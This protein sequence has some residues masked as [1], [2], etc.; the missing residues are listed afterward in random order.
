[1]RIILRDQKQR[2]GFGIN[3]QVVTDIICG[4]IL[5]FIHQFY[6]ITNLRFSRC[7]RIHISNDTDIEVFY[8]TLSLV[9]ILEQLSYSPKEGQQTAREL[10]SFLSTE[11]YL[12]RMHNSNITRGL[13]ITAKQRRSG[14]FLFE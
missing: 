6:S 5:K 1:M 8:E 14:L 2:E 10:F 4:S 9:L 12:I 11:K 3:F 7:A 13:A